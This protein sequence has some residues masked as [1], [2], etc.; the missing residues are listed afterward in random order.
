MT[1]KNNKK[2]KK[3][4][5]KS[6]NNAHLP[7]VSICTPTFNRR[8]FYEITIQCFNHQ[9]YPKDRMEWIIIDDGTDKIEDLI[10]NI[11]QVKYFKYDEKM[12]LGKKRN[13]MHDKSKGDIII[14][15]DDDDY[16]PPERV[17]HAVETLQKNPQAMVAGSSEM[18]IYFKHI[19]KMY[20]FGPY[21][22]NHAT[23]ATFAFRR[24]F[25]KHSR[26]EDNAALAEE[27]HFLKNYT[28]PFVQLDSL[29][30][31]L[32]FSHIH[33]SF[34]KKKLL[35]EQGPNPYVKVSS[36]T[37]DDFVKEPIIKDFFINKIENLLNNY[38]PGRPENKPE[39]LKQIQ[40][41]TEKR[42]KMIEQQQQQP[43]FQP[44]TPEII[45]Q[46]Q[47]QKV[48]PEIIHQL[49]VAGGVYIKPTNI[50]GQSMI[51]LPGQQ[52]Q[53]PLQQQQTIVQQYE[54]R[55]TEQNN[56]IQSL[57][58]DNNTLKQQVEYL[59]KKIKLLIEQ[60]INNKIINKTNET[61]ETIEL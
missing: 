42:Q 28:V 49:H 22:P 34:D 5:S 51:M 8:P 23:A 14:Y 54:K 1:N 45:K 52:Q 2:N 17:S 30:T 59:D 16:Y 9:T 27:K 35:D 46:L 37:I 3:S 19:Q 33:N 13:L 61:N 39:V 44:L 4:N 55:F 57:T 29:K 10:K 20:Q 26:Y 11:P 41:I 15:M 6:N 21:S 48:S 25:L 31:I 56:L 32:V 18:Y 40:E 58:N 38:E 36:K 7:F 43:Q 60:Q 53:P 24:E 50:P 47:D 12:N